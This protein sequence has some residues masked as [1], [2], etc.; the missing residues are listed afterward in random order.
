[1]TNYYYTTAAPEIVLQALR[2]KA[3]YW[4]ESEIP[5]NLRGF[6]RAGVGVRVKGRRFR[7]FRNSKRRPPISIR[8]LRG[9]IEPDAKGGSSI[10]VSPRIMRSWWLGPSLFAILG[11]LSVQSVGKWVVLTLAGMSFLIGIVID[12][13]PIDNN[14]ELQ[15]LLARFNL[16]MAEVDAVQQQGKRAESV[17]P[18]QHTAG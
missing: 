8:E 6:G 15:H 17:M 2:N 18:S 10:T 3:A 16:A 14:P 4:Q 1:M 13:A 11:L 7:V 5:S 9:A 12:R